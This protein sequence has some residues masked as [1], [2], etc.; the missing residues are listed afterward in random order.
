[1]NSN[2]AQHLAWSDGDLEIHENLQKAD[3]QQPHPGGNEV[4]AEQG[5]IVPSFQPRA[6][7][8]RA[9]RGSKRKSGS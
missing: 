4:S 7:Q 5:N 8:R 6:R 1:V 3:D 9:K 2:R